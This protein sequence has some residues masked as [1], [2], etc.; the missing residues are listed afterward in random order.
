MTAGRPDAG[1]RAG[2][3]VATP[4]SAPASA[5]RPPLDLRLRGGEMARDG[6]RALLNLMPPPPERKS[7]LAEAI[8][9]SAKKDCR[10]A[11]AGMGILAVVPLVIDATKTKDNC[12][13]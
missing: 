11:Y 6:S 13:W 3:D 2:A 5:P 9:K 4:P 8:E 10:E 12:K 1:A 7:K